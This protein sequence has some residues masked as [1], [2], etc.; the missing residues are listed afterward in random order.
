MTQEFMWRT[1]PSATVWWLKPNN[2]PQPVGIMHSTVEGWRVALWVPKEKFIAN[3]PA[4]MPKAE[5]LEAAKM[6]ILLSL[7]ESDQ[8]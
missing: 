3:L 6:L 2:G 1:D 5:A 8:S 7:K 4:D